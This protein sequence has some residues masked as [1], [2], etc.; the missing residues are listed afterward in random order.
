MLISNMQTK[1]TGT[2]GFDISA[3]PQ[4]GQ[5][6]PRGFASFSPD[7]A[8]EYALRRTVAGHPSQQP[9]LTYLPTSLTSR[10]HLPPI[11]VT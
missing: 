10:D 3:K 5:I 11:M 9:G 8:S 4:T 7:G 1:G 6:S 2:V